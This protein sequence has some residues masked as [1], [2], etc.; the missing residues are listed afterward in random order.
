MRWIDSASNVPRGSSVTWPTFEKELGARGFDA[1]KTVEKDLPDVIVAELYLWNHFL[2]GSGLRECLSPGLA[3]RVRRPLA[4]APRGP[5][6]R[7][8]R[9]GRLRGGRAVSEGYLMPEL[10]LADRVLGNRSRNYLTE[11]VI[12]RKDEAGAQSQLSSRRLDRLLAVG[13][14][15]SRAPRPGREGRAALALARTRPGPSRRSSL[16]EDTPA[17]QYRKRI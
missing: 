10:R 3:R 4:G 2:S 17:L 12:F 13:V 15:R 6:E 1:K 9:H 8:P 7:V 5:S 11:V 14:R 16:R